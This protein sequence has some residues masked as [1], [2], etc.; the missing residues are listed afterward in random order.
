MTQFFEV[1]LPDSLNRFE[2]GCSAKKYIHSE[3]CCSAEANLVRQ[4]F[5]T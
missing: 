5:K 3:V 4:F 2:C 1:Q